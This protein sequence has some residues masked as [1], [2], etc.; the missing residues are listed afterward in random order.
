[1]LLRKAGY[2]VI[3][4]VDGQD[5]LYKS[6]EFKGTIRLLISD[7]EMPNVTG[8]ELAR[9]IQ[10]ERPEIRVLLMSGNVREC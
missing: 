5:G 3:D 10:I 7:V 1:M 6:R 9:Q 8:F 2:N 4:A